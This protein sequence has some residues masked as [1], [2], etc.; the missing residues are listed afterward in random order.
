M[1]MGHGVVVF[2]LIVLLDTHEDLGG[3]KMVIGMTKEKWLDYYLL[4][5]I[6]VY[7]VGMLVGVINLFI[8]SKIFTIILLSC[9]IIL[10]IIYFLSLQLYLVKS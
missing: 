9:I 3:F 7:I 2:L 5:V 10:F 1:L 8:S 4:I 6:G